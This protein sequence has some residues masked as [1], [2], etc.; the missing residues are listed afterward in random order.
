MVK[1]FSTRNFNDVKKLIAEAEGDTDISYRGLLIMGRFFHEKERPS[2][3]RGAD[4]DGAELIAEFSK[5]L[6]ISKIS[7]FF[8]V[9][10]V[11]QI[12]IEWK[13]EMPN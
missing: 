12:P 9:G 13:M 10:T 2:V 8:T 4:R 3:I 1:E 7:H 5:N 11:T 6:I